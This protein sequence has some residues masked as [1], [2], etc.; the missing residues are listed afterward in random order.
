MSANIRRLGTK[1]RH[2]GGEYVTPG[3]D[4]LWC[5]NGHDKF[6]NYGIKIYAG[7]DAFSRR[8]QW[9]YVG[10]SNRRAV[11]ILHQMATTIKA[12]DR[13]PSFFPSDRGKELLVPFGA[14]LL[15][16]TMNP[17]KRSF[18][19][20]TPNL[21]VEERIRVACTLVTKGIEEMRVEL[22]AEDLHPVLWLLPN[23]KVTINGIGSGAEDS[24]TVAT[25]HTPYHAVDQQA[26][27]F[28]IT[29][30]K[31]YHQGF[32]PASSVAEAINYAGEDWDFTNYIA[33]SG[34]PCP[35]DAITL[36]W[37]EPQSSTR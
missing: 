11:S 21:Y 24:E 31:A 37:V 30:P 19:L 4:W 33:C 18:C 15:S 10:N 36:D 29:F 7:V 8:I 26:G 35:H 20:L 6:R 1:R 23:V 17:R 34:D 16:V 25:L 32:S 28:V 5:I 9:C 12:Y 3:P 13:C 27:Q 22:L 14:V 2:D